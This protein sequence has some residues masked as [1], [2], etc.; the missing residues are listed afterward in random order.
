MG[1]VCVGVCLLTTVLSY[2]FSAH[3]LR[4][5]VKL[6]MYLCV[7][8]CVYVCMYVCMCVCMHVCMYA[9]MYVPVDVFG[10]YGHGASDVVVNPL[11]GRENHDQHTPFR[12]QLPRG[13]I[14]ETIS[15][16]L[17]MG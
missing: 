12:L 6:Y 10:Q 14:T 9:C 7:Y 16:L 17:L 8:L 1:R 15:G 4:C 3:S 2:A 13:D 11:H 5:Y